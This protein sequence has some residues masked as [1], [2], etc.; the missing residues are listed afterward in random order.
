MDKAKLRREL[1]A[2]RNAI[3]PE[4]VIESSKQLCEHILACSAYKEAKTILGYLAFGKELNLD[5]L[6][7]KALEDGKKVYVPHIVSATE[8]VAAELKSMDDF[9][10]DRYGIRCLKE[11]IETIGP[12]KLDLIL[13]PAVAFAKD[14]NR[15]G[16][17]AGYYDR[18]LV[19]CPQAVKIGVAYQALMQ[20]SLPKDRYD[21][22]VPYIVTEGG[23]AKAIC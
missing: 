18:Y 15:L 16:M 11:P 5:L 19:Q 13:V 14:G 21:V 8:F 20:D 6:L 17:G 4:Q 7:T 12:G 3:A 9:A 22:A 2:R 10:L 23:I 1:K